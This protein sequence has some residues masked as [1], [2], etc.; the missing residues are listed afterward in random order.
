MQT[1][2]NQIAMKE[3]TKNWLKFSQRDLKNAEIL[4]RGKSY[5]A[6]IWHCDEAVEKILKAVIIEKKGKIPK[7]H[8]LS[9]LLSES[10]L[11]ISRS[12]FEFIE[13]LNPFYLAPRYP[14][15]ILES[16]KINRKQALNFL[17]LTKEF[18]KWVKFQK[19]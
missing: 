3:S 1:D 7:I 6:C 11:K 16:K 13:E 10:K 12:I 18:I 5:E 19:I 4:F 9:H 15:L 14:E 8:D 2:N 17:K